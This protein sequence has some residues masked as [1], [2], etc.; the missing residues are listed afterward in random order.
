[1]SKHATCG[2]SGSFARGDADAGEAGRVVER[3]E[4]GERVDLGDDVGVDHDRFDEPRAAVDD[5][6]PDGADAVERGARVVERALHRV[7]ARSAV[8]PTT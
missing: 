7:V 6:V 4:L 1:M 2:T 3:C 8:S 5:P